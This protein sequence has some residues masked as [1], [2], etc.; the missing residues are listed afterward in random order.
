MSVTTE[1]PSTRGGLR[2]DESAVRLLFVERSSEYAALVRQSLEETHKGR[3]EVQHTERLDIARR[4]AEEG[5]VDAVLV[6][7]TSSEAG[8]DG[9]ADL[10]VQIDEASSLATRVPVIVL[11]GSDTEEVTLERESETG[12]LE[13]I[14]QSRVPDEILRAVRR[15]RRLGACGAADPVVLRD[16][17]RA[18]AR[19]FARIRKRLA[20][21]AP[22]LRVA[23]R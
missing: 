11:T 22:G 2:P 1:L 15:H 9:P 16:P 14:A 8:S 12:L 3:F 7:L 6:D 19:V 4:H 13:R 18:C 17:L 5:S 23:A 21:S 20:G 10:P